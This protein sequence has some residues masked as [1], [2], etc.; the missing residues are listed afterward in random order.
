[1]FVGEVG[2][3]GRAM[4]HLLMQQS[5]VHTSRPSEMLFCHFAFLLF[6]IL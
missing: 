5:L 1:M 6:S 4:G 3:A 2:G